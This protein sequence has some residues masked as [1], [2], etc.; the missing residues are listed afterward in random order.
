MR[1]YHLA[2]KPTEALALLT[3]PKTVGLFD[4]FTS[5]QIAMDLLLENKMYNEVIEVFKIVQQR[6]I[7]GSK[8]PKNPVILV[9][10]AFFRMVIQYFEN[11]LFSV[12]F[13][14]YILFY[15]E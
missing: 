11:F 9:M 3:N 7:Q 4:Q 8:Y 6:N 2:N 14:Q 15:F 1:F 13:L 10:A 5:Y 12:I